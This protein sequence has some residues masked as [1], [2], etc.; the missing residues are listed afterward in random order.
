MF[1]AKDL[2]EAIGVRNQLAQRMVYCLRHVRVI[3]LLG[4]QGRANLYRLPH[5]NEIDIL[6]RPEK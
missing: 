2:A 5:T 3:E 4:K 6:E 1:T